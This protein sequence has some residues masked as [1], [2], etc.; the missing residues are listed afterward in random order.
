[1]AET[2]LRTTDLC[3][4]YRGKLAVN[5]VNM[6]IEKGQIYGFIGKNGAGKTTLMRLVCNLASRTKGEIELFG[7]S[8]PLELMKARRRIGSMIEVPSLFPN[9][10][11]YENLETQR[12]LI[13]A[14]GKG[15]IEDTLKIV[16]LSDTGRKKVKAF[17]LGMKQRLGLAVALLN[18]PEFLILDEPI[19]GMDPTG[20][21]EIRETLKKLAAE[22]NIT[23]LI[24]SH[25]LTELHQLATH[26]GIIEEGRLLKQISADDLKK[27][28]A[29]YIELEAL[30]T[31]KAA[32]IIEESLGMKNYEIMPHNIIHIFVPAESLPKINEAMVMGGAGLLGITAKGQDLEQYFLGLIETAGKEKA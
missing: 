12:R 8:A 26:Y 30:D 23:I 10:T 25:I 2:V 31:A 14:S 5:N 27:E 19:N 29:S 3:K 24:S 22:R 32:K 11:A 9:M 16:G 7:Q 13:G 4:S 21:V 1:M 15:I 6:V 28:C 18:K 20:I 17:S